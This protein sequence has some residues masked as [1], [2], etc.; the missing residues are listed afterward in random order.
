MQPS[1]ASSTHAA[2][3]DTRYA[4]VQLGGVRHMVEEGHQYTC[5]KSVLD[6]ARFDSASRSIVLHNVLGL[7]DNGQFLVGR[8]YVPNAA[9]E[10]EVLEEFPGPVP[11]S[12]AV[13][14]ADTTMA[15]YR[16]KQISPHNSSSAQQ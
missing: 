13:A 15:I 14:A 2:L 8:P 1:A 16:V 12:T 9:V 11:H 6:Q 3:Q 7:R 5:L 4:I 10:V